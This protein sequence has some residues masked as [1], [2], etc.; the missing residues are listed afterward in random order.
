MS[1]H[2][3]LRRAR[4]V[5]L[6]TGVA[7]TVAAR[8]WQ[9]PTADALGDCHDR[10]MRGPGSPAEC[11]GHKTEH[12]RARTVISRSRGVNRSQIVTGAIERRKRLQQMG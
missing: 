8:P 12:I 2:L 1:A 5:T 4:S 3:L 6:A 7:K 10:S 9:V 11:E